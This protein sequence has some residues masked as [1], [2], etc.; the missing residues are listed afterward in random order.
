MI[1]RLRINKNIALMILIL[2]QFNSYAQQDKKILI[3][4]S[5]KDCQTKKPIYKGVFAT[6]RIK[7]S[8]TI[9]APTDTNGTY[10][11]LTDRQTLS[12]NKCSV[13]TSFVYSADKYYH[14]DC[15]PVAD[16]DYLNSSAQYIFKPPFKD[17]IIN[18][19]CLSP[20]LRCGYSLPNIYFKSNST[21][22]VPIDTASTPA[23]DLA[24]MRCF[25]LDHNYLIELSAHADSKEVDAEAL[26]F[27]RG[28]KVKEELLKLGVP[29]SMLV[30]KGYGAKRLLVTNGE[31]K[32]LP[33]KEEVEAGRT[34]NR[35][36]VFS[37]LRKM[38]Q[39]E[40][41]KKVVPQEDDDE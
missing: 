30:V 27:K 14:E 23:E 38:G 36:V 28:L 22:F 19:F 33:N 15:P 3:T 1:K 5:I 37:V 34:R 32:K 4:G 6:L 40:Q 39:I 31:L 16:N 41:P 9:Y 25:I 18:N 29:D 21:E 10:T 2:L 17:T 24:S 13:S 20:I 7:D 12:G 8:I 26:S 35:R 11:F